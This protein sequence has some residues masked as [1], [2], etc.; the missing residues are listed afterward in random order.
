MKFDHT[1]HEVEHFSYDLKVLGTM[2]GT[3]DGMILDHFKE[4]VLQQRESQ[5][6]EIDDTDATIVIA[7]ILVLFE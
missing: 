4:S 7:R 2:I 5:L 3:S 1:K 6:L